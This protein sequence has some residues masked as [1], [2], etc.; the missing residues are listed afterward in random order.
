MKT[1]LKVVH[2]KDNQSNYWHRYIKEFGKPYKYYFYNLPIDG[3]KQFKCNIC[4]RDFFEIEKLKAHMKEHLIQKLFNCA[5]CDFKCGKIKD[6]IVHFRIAH[7]FK[8]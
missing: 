2:E 1:H 8:K 3:I 7:K 4:F 6:L 5:L